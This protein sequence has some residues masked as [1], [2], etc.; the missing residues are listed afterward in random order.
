MAKESSNPF[1]VRVMALPDKLVPVTTKLITGMPA[2]VTDF[3]VATTDVPVAENVLLL[4]LPPATAA[5]MP[6]DKVLLFLLQL[7]TTRQLTINA[8]TKKRNDLIIFVLPQSSLRK[9]IKR[10]CYDILTSSFS[11]HFIADR[12][13][14]NAI[15]GGKHHFVFFAVGQQAAEVKSVNT[16]A[17]TV[18]GCYGLTSKL[19][20]I[21]VA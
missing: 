20:V 17:P 18:T 4:L 13:F 16:L 10:W 14:C 19:H 5:A 1:I 12:G 8:K 21:K 3:S 9:T 6:L 2:V 7:D 11:Y 15:D